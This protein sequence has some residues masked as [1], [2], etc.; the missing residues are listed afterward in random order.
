MRTHISLREHC[1]VMLWINVD[2]LGMFYSHQNI[3]TFFL[4]FKSVLLPDSEEIYHQPEL[5]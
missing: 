1:S 3:K 2:H 5:I 4:V